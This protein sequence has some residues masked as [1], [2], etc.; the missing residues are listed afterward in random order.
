MIKKVL[1]LVLT[2][3]LTIG[4]FGQSLEENLSNM[5]QS[6]A[7]MYLQPFG[8]AFGANMNSALFHR[9]RVHK[10]LGF[11]LGVKTMWA[12]IPDDAL[13]FQWDLLPEN[14]I[15][16]DL[17][18]IYSGIGSI[19][20]GFD[21]IYN[22]DSVTTPTFFG[23]R[24]GSKLVVNDAGLSDI[25]YN[26]IRDELIAGGMPS[27]NATAVANGLAGE[28]G[29]ISDYV[30]DLPDLPLPPGIGLKAGVPMPMI[31]PQASIGLPLG[32]E[33]MV[34]GVPDIDLPE[35]MGK[36][37]L[38]GGGVRLNLDQFIPIPLFPVDITAGAVF[39]QM[40][41][42]DI[43]KSTNTS[44]NLQVGKSLSLLVFGLGV[45][46]N[47][48]YD[49]STL[50]IAYE[51][52]LFPDDPDNA[53]IPIEFDLETEPGVRFGG[54]FHLTVIPLTYISVGFSQTPTNQVYTL[55]AGLTLR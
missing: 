11:D 24:D 15:E 7:E 51:A 10:M 4:A 55:S 32:I 45:F 33:L 30:G 43:V 38:V 42:G 34:R 31:M 12:A 13:T 49:M 37:N 52:D 3:S 26:H 16:Y 29:A 35:G 23:S 53:L 9:S 48:A 5:L 18:S 46:G 39:Q 47:V 25:F 50:N 14:K 40:S 2:L 36:F 8:E 28:G 22:P 54:G 19:E 1:I 27:A 44:L 21:Q 41:V 17:S 20:L 6:N